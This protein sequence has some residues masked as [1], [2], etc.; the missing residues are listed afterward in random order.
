MHFLDQN[1][2]LSNVKHSFRRSRYY[3]TKLPLCI[4]R[5]TEGVERGHTVHAGYIDFKMAFDSVAH[6]RLG[7][8]V[9]CIG[10]GGGLGC[11]LLN[12]PLA[13]CP[14]HLVFAKRSILGPILL[15]V[16]NNDCVSQL[17]FNMA[18][19]ADD[20]RLWRVIRTAA[21]EENLQVNLNRLNKM[22]KGLALTN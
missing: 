12:W 15:I 3:V 11:I 13:N 19:F 4:E 7:Y 8:K 10:V 21:A 14:D 22:V 9:S 20:I 17:N 6:H 2:L 5:W 16:H 18:I 1:H